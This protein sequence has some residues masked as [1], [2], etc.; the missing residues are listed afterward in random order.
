MCAG[1]CAINET[2]NHLFFYCDFSSSLRRYVLHWLGVS[3]LLSIEA[4]DHA[5][6]FCN[7]YLFGKDAL[8]GIQI[9]WMIC[10]WAL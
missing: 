8:L 2:S 7:Y 5:S 6:Q 1:G 3:S 10:C 9:V 4:Q